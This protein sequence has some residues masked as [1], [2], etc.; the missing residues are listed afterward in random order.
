MVTLIFDC[1]GTLADTERYG[2][3]PAFNE[4]FAE[5]GLGVQWS[6]EEYADRLRIGGG[7]ER[8]AS[9]L[10]PDF[11]RTQGIPDDPDGRRET[12][13]DWHKRKTAH[14]VERV[15]AGLLPPRPGI[16]RLITEALTEGWT[17]AVA[18]TSAVASVEAVVRSA[19][20]PEVA[21]RIPIF[22][23]DAVANKKP[24]PDIYLLA[25]SELGA[26][27]ATTLAIEDSRN[28]YLAARAAGLTC[29]VTVNGYTRDEDF[30]GAAL[31]VSTF[32]DP[33]REQTQVLVD[34]ATARPGP[35]V[36]LA[37]LQRCLQHTTMSSPTRETAMRDRNE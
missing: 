10:T 22:A 3:L 2:H 21:K 32:G 36:T 7:K 35:F 12:L 33:D 15:E 34:T 23:G 17:V 30:T 13:A 14:Y 26:E 6:V 4:T 16:R 19:V 1:D 5:L 8:M 11:E 18:S 20:G 29:V 28:G 25:L 37:E 31:V 27:P 9:L 24:A